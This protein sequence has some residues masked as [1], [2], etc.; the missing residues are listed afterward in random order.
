MSK[1]LN[2][3]VGITE[4]AGEMFGKIMSISDELM[5]RYSLLLIGDEIDP[6][7][8][9]LEEKK[10]LAAKIVTRYH[11]AEAAEQ[12]LANWNNR[13]K[14]DEVE[15]PGFV[16]PADRKDLIGI[17]Q[18]AFDSLGEPKSGSDVRRLIQQ[19]SIQLD[20]EKLPD[21]KSEPELTVGQVLKLNKKRSVRIAN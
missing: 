4:P 1:S 20:G 15:L 2:N 5:V 8:H 3:Y 19:G 13:G 21:P 16:P 9:P 14:L 18:A 10:A 11:S 6:A 17:V 12:A 7:A